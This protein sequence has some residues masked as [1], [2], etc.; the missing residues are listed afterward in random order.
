MSLAGTTAARVTASSFATGKNKDRNPA[1]LIF[2]S[3]LWFSLFF[4][5][6]VLAALILDTVVDG[7]SRFDANLVTQYESTV[8]KDETGFRAG[9]LGT[10]W[11]MLSTAL[12]R[13]RE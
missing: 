7:S 6:M 2:L 3:A 8:R 1:S 9:I 4:G 12:T 10:L 5:V 11:L 13:I